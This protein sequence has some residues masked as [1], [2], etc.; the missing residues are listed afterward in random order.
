M[1]LSTFIG[2]FVV[3]VNT[4][5]ASYSIVHNNCNFT[6][7]ITSVQKNRTPTQKI[8]PGRQYIE[9]QNVAQN[10]VGTS[11]QVLKSEDGLYTG[12][13][14]LTMGYSLVPN[15]TIYYSLSSVNGFDFKGE[16]LRIHNTAGV[17]VEEIVWLGEPKPDYTAAYKGNADLALELCDKFLEKA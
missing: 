14:I 11:V 13:P 4:A 3:A 9:P 8:L 5:F 12:K 7:W 1:H 15:N 2:T 16:K 10:G 6:V 17:S